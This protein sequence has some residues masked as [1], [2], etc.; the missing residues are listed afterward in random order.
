MVA[1][2]RR[3]LC[4]ALT[5]SGL[6]MVG[7]LATAGIIWW[8]A[9][10]LRAQ[11][12]EI[13]EQNRQAASI[14]SQ[15]ARQAS[16]IAERQNQ[17]HALI[18]LQ[19]EWNSDRMI[20]L[21]VVWAEDESDVGRL[22]PILEFL[23]DFARFR[24]DKMLTDEAIWDTNVGWHAALYYFYNRENGNIGKLRIKW[25]DHT[26]FRNLEQLWTA[27][28]QEEIKQGR[29]ERPQDLEEALLQ[30]QEHFTKAEREL[31]WEPR[32]PKS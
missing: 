15:Q 5:I 23:E 7:A 3:W 18:E 12:E 4:H 9:G 11:N 30:T 29:F 10:L 14:A 32:P 27:Y 26:F 17:L 2:A 20:G 24:R 21:R 25:K 8:Q 22:E 16:C 1:D 28:L 19:R 6:T 31:L 13:K